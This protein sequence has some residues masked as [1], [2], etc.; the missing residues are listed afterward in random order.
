MSTD[1]PNDQSPSS[2]V[3][4]SPPETD[5]PISDLVNVLKSVD[6]TALEAAQNA[7]S[8]SNGNGGRIT[9]SEDLPKSEVHDR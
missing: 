9:Y 4:V 3:P 6:T 1:N 7:T 5:N 8:M 2:P